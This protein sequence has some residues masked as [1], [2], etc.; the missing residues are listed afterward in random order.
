LQIC[1]SVWIHACQC[2]YANAARGFTLRR[3]SHCADMLTGNAGT[4]DLVG[5]PAVRDLG[6]LQN[7]TT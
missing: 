6:S 7:D 5:M 1:E 3:V 4:S 2:V